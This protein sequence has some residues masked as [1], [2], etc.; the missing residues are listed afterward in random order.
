MSARFRF[1]DDDGLSSLRG[2]GFVLLCWAG[3]IVLVVTTALA[4]RGVDAVCA[5]LELVTR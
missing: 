5:W 1:E 2:F 4:W 3:W